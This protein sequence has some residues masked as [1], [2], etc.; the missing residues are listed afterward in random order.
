MQENQAFMDGEPSRT[1]IVPARRQHRTELSR[2]LGH[3]S[4]AARL[5]QNAANVAA[6]SFD[7]R[8]PPEEKAMRRLS[9]RSPLLIVAVALMA[10]QAQAQ[11]SQA[12]AQSERAL[13]AGDFAAAHAALQKALARDNAPRAKADLLLQQVRIQ[14]VARLSGL[15]DPQ[16]GATL[17]ALE[18]IAGSDT[19]NRDLKARIAFASA[20][21]EYF[22]RLTGSE[23]GDLGPLQ[24]RFEAA[25]KSL[26]APCQRADALFFAALMP[27]VQDKVAES[28]PGLR[29]A[30]QLAEANRCQL[31]L[32]YDLR[33]LSAVAEAEGDL[34]RARQLAAESLAL[35]QRIGFQVYVPYSLL[36][37]ADL[38]EKLGNKAEA[39]RE[40][41]EALAMAER[42]KLP[43]QA[44]AARKAIEPGRSVV[45]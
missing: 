9:H 40:R 33:H 1:G 15:P 24:V 4:P 42:L 32:S 7:C 34:P 8:R 30:R 36:L 29:Q 23:L 21:S 3:E 20:V 22:Q 10:L 13:Y 45:E 12:I 6:T 16:E 18:R 35:R 5:M 11:L 2:S 37:L 39:E 14:Q 41:R 26:T 25:A 44:E 38:D 31:E 27:Q 19:A 28:A 17:S 43:A